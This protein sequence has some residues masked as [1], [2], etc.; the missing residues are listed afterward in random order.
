MQVL[1]RNLSLALAE[2]FH[3]GRLHQKFWR[4]I[5]P[6]PSKQNPCLIGQ[7][8]WPENE[9]SVWAKTCSRAKRKTNFRQL[10]QIY[11]G[12]AIL[13][14]RVSTLFKAYSM[15]HFLPY[16]HPSPH[17]EP[18][19]ASRNQTLVRLL[20]NPELDDTGSPKGVLERLQCTRNQGE[21][22]TQFSQS[23]DPRGR[24]DKV[25]IPTSS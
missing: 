20:A 16:K 7:S 19:E 17:S 11:A 10:L 8:Q 13:L 24:F 5:R 3:P 18:G 21:H 6:A 9:T 23:D 14:I 2:V 22:T 15:R 4:L 1:Q 12:L 25:S